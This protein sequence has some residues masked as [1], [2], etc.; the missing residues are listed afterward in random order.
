MGGRHIRET[1]I[2]S[3]D[4]RLQIVEKECDIAVAK[5]IERLLRFRIFGW[6]LSS[7]N[8]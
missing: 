6:R 5:N 3:E 7:I 1:A 8:F 4:L 2:S